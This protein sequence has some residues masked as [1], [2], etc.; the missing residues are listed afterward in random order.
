MPYALIVKND[1]KKG[2]KKRIINWEGTQSNRGTKI[3]KEEKYKE[4]RI[5]WNF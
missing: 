3:P 2:K 5:K 1:N 4:K